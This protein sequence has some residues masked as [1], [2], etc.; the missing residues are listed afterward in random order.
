MPLSAPAASLL[1][2]MAGLPRGPRREGCLA[3]WLLLRVA[4]DCLL[5][6]PLAERGMRKRVA[7]LERRLS[8]LTLPAPLRRALTG[9]LSELSQPGRAAAALVLQ[10]LTAPARETLGAEAGDA[11][12]R[13]ARTAAQRV[14]EGG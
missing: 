5:D 10:Q 6:P 12:T 9:A 3:L 2:L 1:E 14:R 13:A 11:L 8:S 4:E 7:A